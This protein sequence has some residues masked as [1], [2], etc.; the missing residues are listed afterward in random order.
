MATKS[1][2][3]K[4]T[5]S[6]VELVKRFPV[7]R[8]RTDAERAE[9]AGIIRELGMRGDPRLDAG[10]IDYIEALGCFIADF[11]RENRTRRK[12]SSPLDLLKSLLEEN[13]LRPIDL[14]RII[15]SVSNATMILQGKREL[16]KE[17][18]R[19]LSERFNV[20]PGL[21]L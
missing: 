10:E 16:S 21:F 2:R 5:D 15:G 20:S 8:I 14:G 9:A 17:H 1:R 13:G 4:T 18:I 19:K 11:E 3:A 12:E 6:Y 7:R